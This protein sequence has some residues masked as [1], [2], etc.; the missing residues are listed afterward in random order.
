MGSHH[1][2]EQNFKTVSASGMNFNFNC[3]FRSHLA[4]PGYESTMLQV[5][6]QNEQQWSRYL[7]E[8]LIPEPREVLL[9]SNS[10][11]E[12]CLHI[13]HK[14]FRLDSSNPA[15]WREA[16]S[17][18]YHFFRPHAWLPGPSGQYDL[19]VRTVSCCRVRGSTNNLHTMHDVV[20]EIHP[21]E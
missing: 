4:S 9:L 15:K 14:Y 3:G 20:A 21:W 13:S 5:D 10:L 6:C 17:Q 2:W 19:L 18:D 16:G 1:R 12:L 11:P 8:S 7:E